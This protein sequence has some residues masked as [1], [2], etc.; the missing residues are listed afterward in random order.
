MNSEYIL[1]ED[2]EYNNSTVSNTSS[3][4]FSNK[5]TS[6]EI[7]KNEKEEE[8]MDIQEF[9]ISHIKDA[10]IENLPSDTVKELPTFCK[11]NYYFSIN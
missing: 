8:S 5:K 3:I 6:N 9:V 2:K 7:I 1:A 10:F 11:Y 4:D